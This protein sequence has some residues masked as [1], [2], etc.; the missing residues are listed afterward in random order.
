VESLF[1]NYMIAL[2]LLCSVSTKVSELTSIRSTE[3]W[4]FRLVVVAEINLLLMVKSFQKCFA[5][6]L[7]LI[8]S[9]CFY[10]CPDHLNDLILA[11]FFITASHNESLF[12]SLNSMPFAKLEFN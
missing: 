12:D 1:N 10:P 5:T 11:F 8:N 9:R 7:E 2:V 3:L 6:V 4:L